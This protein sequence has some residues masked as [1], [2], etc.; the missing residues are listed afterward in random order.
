[1]E[2]YVK[3]KPVWNLLSSSPLQFYFSRFIIYIKINFK[4]FV[5]RVKYIH[6]Y[7][8]VD[9]NIFM[10]WWLLI[11]YLIICASS[12]ISLSLKKKKKPKCTNICHAYKFITFLFLGNLDN[13]IFCDPFWLKI[14]LSYTEAYIMLKEV[15]CPKAVFEICIFFI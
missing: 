6:I 1:M 12:V 11:K 8:L 14:W 5:N 4:R 3:W 2:S 7:I 15:Q 10:A 13:G 9:A